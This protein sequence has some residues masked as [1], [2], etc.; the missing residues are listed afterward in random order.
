MSSLPC[1]N[2]PILLQ[3]LD[4]LLLV[5]QKLRIY[6]SVV[7]AE[8]GGRPG[9]VARRLAHLKYRAG[10][11]EFPAYQLLHIHLHIAAV[12]L[13]VVRHLAECGYRRAGQMLQGEFLS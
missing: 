2:H 9:G 13:W 8:E 11:S 6:L 4:G 7:L 12:K 1:L 3:L 10:D 5:A